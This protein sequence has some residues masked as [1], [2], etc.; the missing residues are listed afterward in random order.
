M[1]AVQVAH[2]VGGGGEGGGA[3]GDGDGVQQQHE[4]Q[5]G[6]GRASFSAAC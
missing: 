3:L 1:A 4:L 6:V 2:Y 5:R